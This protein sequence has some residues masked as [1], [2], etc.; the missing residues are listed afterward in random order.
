M[1]D[2]GNL[3]SLT[4]FFFVKKVFIQNYNMNHNKT[5]KGGTKD[6]EEGDDVCYKNTNEKRMNYKHYKVQHIEQ[7]R[8]EK[9]EKK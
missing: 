5:I 3:L 7:E 1:L 4:V 2:Y 6:N 9:Q 8:F